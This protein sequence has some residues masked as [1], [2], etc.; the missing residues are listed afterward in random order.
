MNTDSNTKRWIVLLDKAPFILFLESVNYLPHAD[1]IIP[2]LKR[3]NL[4]FA[5][6]Y[7]TINVEAN[8][9]LRK[10]ISATNKLPDSN[11]YSIIDAL[12]DALPQP[13]GSFPVRSCFT[14]PLWQ[15]YIKWQNVDIKPTPEHQFTITVDR[16]THDLHLI[17]SNDLKSYTNPLD[18]TIELSSVNINVPFPKALLKECVID[19]HEIIKIMSMNRQ[20]EVI[21]KSKYMSVMHTGIN[22]FNWTNLK[23]IERDL[24]AAIKS[25]NIT[26]EE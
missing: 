17:Y 23:A 26:I 8:Q 9:D 25:A 4:S 24:I 22:I 16:H 11:A 20:P 18:G 14:S 15:N 13:G 21:A 3:F 5:D 12:S 6:A 2:A 10:I 1:Y 7:Q 19:I